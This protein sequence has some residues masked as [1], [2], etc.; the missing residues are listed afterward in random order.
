MSDSKNPATILAALLS[1]LS[2][3]NVKVVDLELDPSRSFEEQFDEVEAQIRA[4]AK[5]EAA[6]HRET[7]SACRAK[8][9]EA[10]K[11]AA[12]PAEQTA[13]LYGAGA[14]NAERMTDALKTE[15]LQGTKPIFHEIGFMAFHQGKPIV[16]SFRIDR[17]EVEKAYSDFLNDPMVVLVNGM[18]GIDVR[19]EAKHI[20]IRPVYDRR[21][22]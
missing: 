6:A 2:T 21:S 20:E 5:K 19:K 3:G 12:A 18:M 15:P 1:G 10:Q 13:G 17:K 7:C 4:A 14:F 22:S 11:K 9:E 8:Y 16:Q